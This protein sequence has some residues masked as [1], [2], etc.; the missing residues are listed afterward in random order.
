MHDKMYNTKDTLLHSTL[1]MGIA[2]IPKSLYDLDCSAR[3]LVVLS[4][5]D[6]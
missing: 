1:S 4:L 6:S 2:S 5:A 3:L